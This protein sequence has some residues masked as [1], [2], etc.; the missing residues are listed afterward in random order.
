MGVLELGIQTVCTGLGV[1][2]PTGL[3]TQCGQHQELALVKLFVCFCNGQNLKTAV[4]V[5]ETD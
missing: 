4:L 2:P 1:L 3:F 5:N